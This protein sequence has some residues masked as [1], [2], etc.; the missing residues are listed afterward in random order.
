MSRRDNGIV[1]KD[2]RFQRWVELIF[3]SLFFLSVFFFFTFIYKYHLHFE[4][5]MQLFL[6]S[7]DYLLNS[8]KVPGGLAGYSGEFLVQFYYLPVAGG[9]IITALL[10]LVQRLVKQIVYTLKPNTFYF[11]LTF[12]PS[13]IYWVMLC[14]EFYALSGLLGFIGIL[15]FAKWYVSIPGNRRRRV[16]GWVMVPLAYYLFGGGYLSL[17][18]ILIAFELLK[19]DSGIAQPSPDSTT[20]KLTAGNGYKVLSALLLILLAVFFPLLVRRLFVLE[21]ITMAYMTPVYYNIYSPSL[22]VFAPPAILLVFSSVPLLMVWFRMSGMKPRRNKKVLLLPA[23]V[24]ALMVFGGIRR[25][26]NPLSEEVM[27]YDHLAR[28]EKWQEI[29]AYAER[30]PPRNNN[31]SLSMLN[32]AMAKT[33]LMPERMFSFTQHD[34]YGLFVPYSAEYALPIFTS[35]VFYQLGLINAAQ[36]YAFESLSSTPDNKQN[37]RAIKRLAETNLINGQYRVADKYIRLL[38]KTLFYRK[39]AKETRKL[40]YRDEMIDN[41]PVYGGKRKL[42]FCED[43]FFTLNDIVTV[44]K[45]MLETDPENHLACQY[46]MAYYLVNK[47]LDNFMANLY[48]LDFMHY[49]ALPKSYQEAFVYVITQPTFNA[50]GLKYY[51]INPVIMSQLENYA[52]V[53]N[54]DPNAPQTLGENFS[55]TYWYF[56]HFL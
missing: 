51:P 32:L 22:V 36:Q 34:S 41:D 24:M 28:N 5:Q 27:A 35:E 46:L 3:A 17:A 14:D 16:A 54:Q 37:V 44:L 39:W 29:I 9:L 45:K 52:Y 48:R 1:L 4:E 7:A 23:L 50:E 43:F 13:L 33:D 19:Q 47:D 2:K 8:L 12:V 10:F 20:G 18:S 6:W 55:D 11:P 53:Y 49:D 21:N 56:L 31:L 15:F 42:L 26:M 30:H 38:E 25:N 40:L